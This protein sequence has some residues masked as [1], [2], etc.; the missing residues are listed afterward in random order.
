MSLDR[1][2]FALGLTLSAAG[3]MTPAPMPIPEDQAGGSPAPAPGSSPDA[4][5]PAPRE[6][7]GVWVATVA[8]IDWPSRP[9]LP[10]AQQQAEMHAILDRA[11]AI[12]LNAL[13]LQVR[14]AADA[15]Y[16][17]PLEP[18][19]EFLS[20]AQGRP[21]QPSYDPLALWVQQAHRRGLELHAWFNPYR[22][23]HSTSRSAPA[24][25]HVTQARPGLV[26]RYGDQWWMDP[27]EPAAAEQT[28]AVV[29]DVLQRYEVDGIHIDDYFYPY[30]V[31]LPGGGGDLPFPDDAPYERYRAAGGLLL[32]D[33]W[34]RDNVDRL[35][36]AMHQ[37]VQRLRPG[38]RFGI[39]PFGLGRPDLRPPGIEGFSQYDKLYADV[40][41]WVE[42]GWYDYLVPQLYWAID[43][44]PQA[45]PVLLD[46][47]RGQVGG[48]RHMWPGLYTSAIGL[49][50]RAWRADELLRQVELTRLRETGGH[51]HF[52]MVA[53]MQDRDGIAT[54]LQ[55]ESYRTPALA[56]ASPW[57]HGSVP[58]APT[59]AIARDTVQILAAADGEPAF[60]W[61]VWRHVAGQWRFD[62]QP[63]AQ[64]AVALMTSAR[65]AVP[66]AV[67]VSAVS[68]S[69]HES[70][71]ATLRLRG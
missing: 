50:G 6:F 45:F 19:S 47:W 16:P 58:Q 61:A 34:R 30:P 1:R 43:R 12:G 46:Y 17:S 24:A 11:R 54:R 70:P 22:A 8:N 21:P 64:S 68:R 41:R 48:A 18:W 28:L 62:V 40:E 33:D 25:S 63:A 36:Q 31:P 15:L 37:A 5:P 44:A 38:A 56:P 20:G 57:L 14:P 10:A 42:R 27:G 7:R 13:V 29:A 60:N 65:E 49:P 39:S 23:G 59:L 55:Q 51:I 2:A 32:R 26:R 35:V 66:D 67:V 4:P 69:G 3:C 71:R 53:L 9:G 52:S